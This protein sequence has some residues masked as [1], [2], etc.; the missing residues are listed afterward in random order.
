MATVNRR[1]SGKWQ[2]TVR[3]I[4]RSHSESFTMRAD[5]LRW[6]RETELQAERGELKC[7]PT[8]CVQTMSLKAVLERYRDNVTST[9]RCS[10]NERYA[11][12][13]F[14]RSRS[15]LAGKPI[16][17]LTTADFVSH[18]DH[19]LLQ[20]KP[21]TVVRELGWIQHAIDIACTDWGQ[22]LSDGNPVK[23]VRRPR[24]DNRRERRLQAGEWQA[25]LSAVSETRTPFMKP[26]LML[27]LATGMRRGE[28]LAM[29]WK[30]VELHRHTVFLPMTKNGRP[31]TVPLCPTAVRVLTSLPSDGDKCI[32]LTGNSVRLAF[33]RLRRRAGVIDLTFHDIRHEAVSRFVEMGLSLAQV[34][35]ISGYRDLRMLMRYTHLQTDDI[36]LKLHSVMP[37]VAL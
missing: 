13:G 29:K 12:N 1:P 15:K 31:R 26:L 23:L 33:E 8:E 10:D 34:Q 32:P 5:A 25:L 7:S 19:R 30:D 17:K 36:V 28:L 6:A 18:R 3:K 37:D 16:D 2:A 9:K 22:R 35:M 4:G 14:L 27:A 21:A 20:M 11:I 24:I